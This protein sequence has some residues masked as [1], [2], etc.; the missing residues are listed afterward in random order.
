MSPRPAQRPNRLL[1]GW[2]VINPVGVVLTEC[3]MDTDEGSATVTT[4]WP[5]GLPAQ[6]QELTIEKLLAEITRIRDEARNERHMDNATLA[7]AR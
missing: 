5:G 1:F 4:F 3:W 6:T 7:D 2:R